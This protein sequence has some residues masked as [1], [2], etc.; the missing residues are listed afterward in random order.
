MA[1]LE[2]EKEEEEDDDDDDDDEEEEEEDVGAVGC[3]YRS[4]R[5][6]VRVYSSTCGRPRPKMKVSPGT[7]QHRAQGVTREQSRA[8]RGRA[9]RGRGYLPGQK[10]TCCCDQ[11]GVARHE[12]VAHEVPR[13]VQ[14][15]RCRHVLGCFQAAAPRL[16]V[17]NVQLYQLPLLFGT[18]QSICR[19]F[20][21]FEL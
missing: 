4:E 17:P 14:A 21:S 13:E 20:G 16:Q 12:G 5:S 11:D 19:E 7:T 3:L 9:G 10:D 6:T 18:E 2:E 15:S 1:V 8:R